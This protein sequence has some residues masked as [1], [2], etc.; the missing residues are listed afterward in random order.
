MAGDSQAHS[1]ALSSRP[2]WLAYLQLMRLPNVFTAL[3]DTFMGYWMVLSGSHPSVALGLALLAT[4]C[5]YT[6][7]MVLNDLFDLE[8]DRRER[9]FRPLPSGRVPIRHAQWLGWTL[10]VIG[11]LA[12][13]SIGWVSEAESRRYVPALLASVLAGMIVAYDAWAKPTFLGP[14]LMGACRSGNILLAMGAAWCSSSDSIRF[15]TIEQSTIAGAIGVYVVGITYFAR[16]EAERSHRATLLGGLCC[17]ASGWL[18]LAAMPVSFQAHR[19]LSGAALV[20]WYVLIVAAAAPLV[21]RLILAW[22]EP[23]P[24][25]VQHAVRLA[26]WSLLWWDTALLLLYPANR[27]AALLVL[28]LYLPMRWLGRRVYAT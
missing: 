26:I 24:P 25:R 19:R 5:L 23:S 1:D 14:W 12:G 28:F 8:Q 2:R 22:E 4:A 3:A 20:C 7:G 9:P 27:W 13:V 21:R 18:L 16:T 11:W 17:M 10:L 15:A 6:A